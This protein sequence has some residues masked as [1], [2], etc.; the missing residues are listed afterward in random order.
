MESLTYLRQKEVNS[1]IPIDKHYLMPARILFG[2][3]R[4]IIHRE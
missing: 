4:A 3:Q 1:L 2:L